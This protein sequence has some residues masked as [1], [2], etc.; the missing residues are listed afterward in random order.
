MFKGDAS[1]CI[2]KASQICK[3]VFVPRDM[4]WGI[5][6]HFFRPAIKNDREVTQKPLGASFYSSTNKYLTAVNL[7]K[8]RLIS[9]QSQSSSK[10]GE[11]LIGHCFKVIFDY[12]LSPQS[13]CCPLLICL[14]ELVIAYRLDII[15]AISKRTTVRIL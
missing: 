8:R 4:H 14:V 5:L 3:A 7:A 9:Q 10:Q 1:N 2:N 15:S 11:Y 6:K 13:Y 12:S